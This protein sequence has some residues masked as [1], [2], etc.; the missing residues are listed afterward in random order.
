MN[1]FTSGVAR[2]CAWT[3]VLSGPTLPPA[4]KRGCSAWRAGRGGRLFLCGPCHHLAL[5]AGGTALQ[6]PSSLL[7]S[8]FTGQCSASGLCH[9]VNTKKILKKFLRK[10]R[11]RKSGEWAIT[12]RRKKPSWKAT[13]L[14]KG[15]R[16]EIYW[17]GISW[18]P[19]NSRQG[20]V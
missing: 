15:T 20:I 6:R 18:Q 1:S 16:D 9:M 4:R 17:K 14:G 7:L 13:G 12:R 5:S 11:E 2:P 19:R 10:K 3:T 8:G